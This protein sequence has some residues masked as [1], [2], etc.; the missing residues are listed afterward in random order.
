MSAHQ[1]ALAIEVNVDSAA[2]VHERLNVAVET[3]RQKA[4]KHSKHSK[5]GILVTQ[6]GYGNF[7]MA[8]SPE[9]PFGL[10][11][12]RRLVPLRKPTRQGTTV[13]Q[14]AL[15][16]TGRWTRARSAKGTGSY[17]NRQQRNASRGQ[18]LPCGR[19]GPICVAERSFNSQ[20]R[21]FGA[22]LATPRRP[23]PSTCARGSS[24]PRTI[25]QPRQL[26]GRPK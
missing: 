6:Y 25:H 15:R 7:K 14:R 16:I 22:R 23:T 2:H 4:I 13:R 12:E 1:S 19:T 18:V 26:L 9:V 8:I 11:L 5:H 3:A 20:G 10:T 24:P 21:T 17:Q